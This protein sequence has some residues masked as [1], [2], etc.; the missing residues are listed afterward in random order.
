[1]Y[2]NGTRILIKCLANLA[3]GIEELRIETNPQKESE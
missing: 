2:R 1:M 3:K